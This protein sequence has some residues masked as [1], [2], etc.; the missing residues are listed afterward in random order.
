V[1]PARILHA[2]WGT[3]PRKRWVA[4][5]AWSAGAWAVRAVE[6]WSDG[7]LA[8]LRSGTG[9]LAGFD[10]P[11]GLPI[12]YARRAGIDGFREVLPRLGAPGPFAAF[13]DICAA[14]SDISLG[15]PFYPRGAR[16]GSSRDHLREGLG[17]PY[18]EL[19]RACDRA[20]PTRRE[21]C[22]LFW[23]LGAT[24][25]GRGAIAGWREVVRPALHRGAALWPFDG[26]LPGL[27][28]PGGA[29]LAETYPAEY[30]ARLGLGGTRW[31]KRDRDDRATRGV[32]A[33]AWAAG[34][35]IAVDVSVGRRTRDGFGAGS[36]GEDPFDA[37]MGLLG[38]IGVVDDG[39]WAI[40]DD[41]AVRD[42]EGWILGQAPAPTGRAPR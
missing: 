23:V 41:P 5:A 7:H 42:V 2:D 28:A 4:S 26:D 33:L 24:Q 31:S 32:R 18:D 11:I 15:R 19:L 34:R 6:P 20:T 21:A 29:V 10:F 13:F 17:L 35:D 25:A 27:L 30:S 16:A 40:P 37:L 12:A 8:A 9:V 38:M 1:R 39:V 3:D 22:A 36:A 14:P